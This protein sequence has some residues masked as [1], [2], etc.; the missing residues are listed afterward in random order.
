MRA[1]VAPATVAL[2]CVDTVIPISIF[3]VTVYDDLPLISLVVFTR[4]IDSKSISIHGLRLIT[5][6]KEESYH[7]SVGEFR[8][9]DVPLASTTVNKREHRQ[10]VLVVGSWVALAAFQSGGMVSNNV[11]FEYATDHGVFAPTEVG[12]KIDIPPAASVHHSRLVGPTSNPATIF[13][14]KRTDSQ[15]RRYPFQSEETYRIKSPVRVV[16]DRYPP[17]IGKER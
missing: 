7:R 11:L 14:M 9:D 3:A 1:T 10:L 6:H 2:A 15:S 8:G 5:N 4:I 12:G 16:T 13:Y 17:P